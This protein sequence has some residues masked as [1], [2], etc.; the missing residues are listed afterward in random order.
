MRASLNRAR[1]RPATT[2]ATLDYASVLL[3]AFDDHLERLGTRDNRF[4]RWCQSVT[5]GL[6]SD[7]HDQFCE[8][9][10]KLG[11][12][13]G[14]VVSRPRHQAATDC[15]WRGVFGNQKEVVTFEV[16]IEHTG[17]MAVSP[18]DIGQA[19]NQ[20]ARAQTEYG[21]TGYRVRGT[22]VTHMTAIDPAADASAGSIRIVPK[23]IVVELWDRV[24]LLLSLYR[25]NWSIDDMP[26]RLSAAGRI[27]A[28]IPQT[29]W[30]VAALD[31][32]HRF[33]SNDQ[34]LSKWGDE[35]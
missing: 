8:A 28:R 29:G 27:H 4:E 34:L 22:I 11:G 26:A 35:T 24:R 33:I 5:N 1:Q 10:E 3:R 19:H 13:L 12:V 31:Q 15:R 23:G 32:D 30:L 17:Q 16:K 6:Q 7:R 25:D 21:R 20:V 9:L 2:P 14:Y 18:T